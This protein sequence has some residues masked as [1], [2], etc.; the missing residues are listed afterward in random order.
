[1]KNVGRN[2]PPMDGLH[3]FEEKVDLKTWLG[4]I[5]LDDVQFEKKMMNAKTDYSRNMRWPYEKDNYENFVSENPVCKKIGFK[6][7]KLGVET[8]GQVLNESL[9]KANYPNVYK[10]QG[11]LPLKS[12]APHVFALAPGG[13]HKDFT[14]IM[15]DKVR[16]KRPPYG[17]GY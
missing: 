15:R 10:H 7:R 8:C 12:M 13:E 9:L 16:V 14:R 17:N 11:E 3:T 5:G 4:N 6:S 2:R 1:M